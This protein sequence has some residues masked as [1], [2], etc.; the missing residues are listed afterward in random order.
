M[1]AYTMGKSLFSSG[2]G[3]VAC[4]SMKLEHTYLLIIYK[5]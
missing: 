4:K 2:I 3:K 1:Q 5:K